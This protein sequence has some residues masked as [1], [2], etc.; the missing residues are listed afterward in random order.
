MSYRSMRLRNNITDEKAKNGRGGRPLAN[1]LSASNLETQR[2]ALP[3]E[4]E[5]S[6]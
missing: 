5:K 1:S 2:V 6:V 4:D 3:G